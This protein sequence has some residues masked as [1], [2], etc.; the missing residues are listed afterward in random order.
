MASR[1]HTYNVDNNSTYNHEGSKD[2][3]PLN[4]YYEN[5]HV[6]YNFNLNSVSGG[7]AT[8]NVD[9]SIE[10]GFGSYE[11]WFETINVTGGAGNDT[12]NLY[13][14]AD[15]G[16]PS[17]WTGNIS[18]GDGDDHVYM[19]ETSGK[20]NYGKDTISLG[21]GDDYAYAG[22]ANDYLSGGSG[23]DTID[24]GSGTDTLD[25]GDGDD[26][27]FV[28]QDDNA[29][30]GAGDDI[31]YVGLTNGNISTVTGGDGSDLFSLDTDLYVTSDGSN[32][33]S[34]VDWG[35]VVAGS[36]ANNG[37]NKF[38]TYLTTGV[39][40]A[41]SSWNPFVSIGISLGSTM[42]GTLVTALAKDKTGSTSTLV[43]GT[44]TLV[45]DFD[46]MTD[47]INFTSSTNSAFTVVANTASGSG[48]AVEVTDGN[49]DRRALIYLSTDFVDLFK[50]SN[51]TVDNVLLQNAVNTYLGAGL[52]ITKDGVV[53][54]GYTYTD[55]AFASAGYTDSDGGALTVSDFGVD[56]SNTYKFVWGSFAGQTLSASSATT[57]VAGTAFSDVL[58]AT[59]MTEYDA[60]ALAS[61]HA[62]TQVSLHGG[63]GADV[64]I[65]GAARDYLNGGDGDDHLFG[66]GGIDTMAGGNGADAFH[67]ATE[68]LS[69]D[70]S[71]STVDSAN[72]SD[73]LIADFGNLDAIWIDNADVA[74]SDVSITQSG[75]NVTVSIAKYGIDY[76][77]TPG[78]NVTLTASSFAVRTDSDTGNVYITS[79][80]GISAT[81]SSG[82]YGNDTLAAGSASSTIY[83]G[84]GNDTVT[85]AYGNTTIYGGEGNDNITSSATSSG[86]QLYG[87]DGVDYMTGGQAAEY[88]DGGDGN[89]GIFAY[90]ENDTVYGGSG[91]DWLDG[92]EGSDLVYGGN[93]NDTVY[94]GWNTDTLSGGAGNDV[95]YVKNSGTESGTRDVISDFGLT[96]AN[97]NA[98]LNTT[99][100]ID[101]IYIVDTSVRASDISFSTVNDSDGSVDTLISFANNSNSVLLDS[102]NNDVTTW[103]TST[104]SS[105]HVVIVGQSNC[106]ITTAT[107]EQFGWADNCGVLTV[108]RWFRDNVMAE[109]PDWKADIETYYRIAPKIVE[110]TRHDTAL[111]QKLW[112]RFLRKAVAAVVAGKYQRAYDIYRKMVDDLAARHLPAD[113]LN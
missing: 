60:D 34:D 9:Y 68:C 106:F 83:G 31:F 67:I 101:K 111:Y 22:E 55:A 88:I 17:D 93:G 62:N 80:S 21:N 12:F 3:N 13:Y 105:G 97:G 51:G 82:G 84:Y 92:G 41:T 75:S 85:T 99:R 107:A 28:G 15:E 112:T 25:G 40:S 104:D 69:D 7:S 49:S 10:N 108:L 43:D 50:N 102:V 70:Q 33:V 95:F 77:V 73:G 30:G 14:L 35:S 89:D 36:V 24:G 19:A 42:I 38:L 32:P 20:S 76:T 87:E 11:A 39:V 23:D 109:R 56:D 57:K 72:E 52:S 18:M 37:T 4:T 46:P 27:I 66:L 100:G 63:G 54:N 8:A 64:L 2:Y 71:N 53:T 6:T 47:A 91:D 65:G 78:T 59:S 98:A 58:T 48:V 45:E 61:V 86:N 110:A 90:Q 26:I 44:Y 113:K 96:N 29:D 81:G 16:S 103:S 1:T 79:T 94:G 5:F 74:A